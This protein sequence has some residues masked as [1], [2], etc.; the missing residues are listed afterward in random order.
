MVDQRRQAPRFGFVMAVF[1]TLL[2]VAVYRLAVQIPIPFLDA[3]ALDEYTDTDGYALRGRF[4]VLALG[5]MPYLSASLLVEIF[6]L[7]FPPL[8]QF[9]RGDHQGRR[10]LKHVALVITCPL[11]AIQ[12]AGIISVW[13]EISPT[14]EGQFLFINSTYEHI[15]LLASLVVAVYF[16]VIL[17]E[18]ISRI[19]L[20]HGISIIIL[21]SLGAG[22]SRGLVR[23]LVNLGDA[24]PRDFLPLL[25]IVGIAVAAVILLRGKVSIPVIHKSDERPLAI[26]Q[27]NTSPSGARAMSFAASLLMLPGMMFGAMR[28]PVRPLSRP[29]GWLYNCCFVVLV[30]ALSCL[31]AWL[32]FHPQRRLRRL[33]ERGWELADPKQASERSLV[34]KLLI[35]NLPWTVLL[36][37][38][39]VVP[40]VMNGVSNVLYRTIFMVEA[41]LLLFVAVG[42]DIVDRYNAQRGKRSVRLVRIAEFHD[43]YDASMV[44]AHLASEGI[45]CHLQGY[46]HRCLL[47]FFG[48]Y[49]GIGLL[50]D[51]DAAERCGEILR[52]YYNS[53]GLLRP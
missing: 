10:K 14:G 15:L 49:I 31:L 29:D 36:C 25:W 40:Y 45:A 37:A 9:R 18:V 4:S 50:V 43:V 5:I 24:R 11:A 1:L 51:Q 30:F 7:V 41:S 20:V 17:S 47:Y 35:Y 42:M 39:G 12:A 28:L 8:K 38:V 19:G 2:L 6:S 16:L 48:P 46:Y 27:F 52:R 32:F 13:R 22:I 21:S 33:R 34:R 3:E 26:F 23:D 44:R 53:L